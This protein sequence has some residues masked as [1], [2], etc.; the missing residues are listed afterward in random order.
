MLETTVVDVDRERAGRRKEGAL[1]LN[2][3][4]FPLTC[5]IFVKKSY[6]MQSDR[7]PL[8]EQKDFKMTQIKTPEGQAVNQISTRSGSNQDHDTTAHRSNDKM[9]PQFKKGRNARM[10]GNKI[11]IWNRHTYFSSSRFLFVFNLFL[12]I[13]SKLIYADQSDSSADYHDDV[14]SSGRDGSEAHNCK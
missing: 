13:G 10:S 14:C 2:A 8:D 6:K 5:H 7:R 4:K 12:L 9:L 11:I 1:S 3:T